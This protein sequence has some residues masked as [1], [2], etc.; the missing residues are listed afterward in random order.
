ME[1]HKREL[2]M[3]LSLNFLAVLTLALCV[4]TIPYT[5]YSLETIANYQK[6]TDAGKMASIIGIVEA[7]G[8]KVSKMQVCNNKD[9]IHNPTDTGAD[10]E[11][12]VGVGNVPS[13]AITA[14]SLTTTCPSGWSDYASAEGRVIIGVGTLGSDSYGLGNIGGEA[15]HKLTVNEMPS[16]IHRADTWHSGGGSRFGGGNSGTKDG[17]NSAWTNSTGGDQSHENRPPYIALKYCQKD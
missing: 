5:G 8:T 7:L 3:K 14:F 10:L 2:L 16:H 4:N 12:C 9:M 1:Q 6:K 17:T 13:G 15:R 11:G